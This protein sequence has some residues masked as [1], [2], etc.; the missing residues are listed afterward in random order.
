M[1]SRRVIAILATVVVLFAVAWGIY[2]LGGD[3]YTIDA[4]LA[5]TK[6]NTVMRHIKNGNYA[7]AARNIGFY[8]QD[9]EEAEAEW[10]KGMSELFDG[11]LTVTDY[12]VYLFREDDEFVDGVVSFKVY[13]AAANT[14]WEF[15]TRAA[16]QDGGI[17]FM[18]Q[19]G[20]LSVYDE[21][22]EELEELIFDAMSTWYAG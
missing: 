7:A 4:V 22:R 8:G 11:A 14:E 9:R 20:L 17:A 12:K 6:A 10:A 19:T 5:T 18:N 21:R 2:S 15:F 1:N 13:D 16:E 3:G